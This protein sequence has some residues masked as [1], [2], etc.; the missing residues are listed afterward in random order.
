MEIQA[1][2]FLNPQGISLQKGT[3]MKTILV[4]VMK[5]ILVSFFI[6]MAASSSCLAQ[7]EQSLTVQDGSC[8]FNAL[9][10]MN[11]FSRPV[12]IGPGG[13][14]GGKL[15]ASP[16]VIVKALDKCSIPLLVQLVK[17]GPI[18]TIVINL[19]EVVGGVQKPVLQ[20][21]VKNAFVTDIVD[22]D[23][24]ATVPS[25]K[26]TVAY[27]TIQISDPIHG[28]SVTCDFVNQVCS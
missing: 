23:A 9:S 24:N 21:S 2:K 6:A 22:A 12:T 28:T 4:T 18:P 16:I 3:I 5:T 19:N 1:S 10:L 17:G 20:I 11:G 26:V 15:T 25:E 13:V 14:S 27:E 7:V 8:T